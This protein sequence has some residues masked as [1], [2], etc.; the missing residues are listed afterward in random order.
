MIGAFGCTG[1]VCTAVTFTPDT[2]IFGDQ[3]FKPARLFKLVR[4]K[5]YLFAGVCWLPGRLA[6]RQDAS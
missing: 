1:G 4:S 6:R 5:A 2:E 3:K